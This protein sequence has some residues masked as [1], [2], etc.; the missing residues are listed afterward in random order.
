MLD[1]TYVT[2]ALKNQIDSF[3]HITIQAG[4]P[5]NAVAAVGRITLT[6]LPS[7]NNTFAIN[8]KT[9]TWVAASANENEVTIG[10]TA[11][12]SIDNAVTIVNANS[13]LSPVCVAVKSGTDKLQITWSTKG[14][15]GNAKH[16]VKSMANSSIDGSGFLGGT[17]AGVDGT[18][19]SLNEIKADTGYV[20]F[21]IAANTIAG[22]NWRRISLGSAY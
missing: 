20:Y 9:I 11:E 13:V 18:V 8:D 3:G 16:F 1:S 5:V 19:G 2:E 7:V 6:G 4:T 10:D 14:V 12:H 17:T 22:T 21:A 15:I